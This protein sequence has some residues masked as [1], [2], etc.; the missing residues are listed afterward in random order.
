MKVTVNPC[1][2]RY[3]HSREGLAYVV[4]ASCA[5]GLSSVAK[6]EPTPE[7]YA[8]SFLQAHHYFEPLRAFALQKLEEYHATHSGVSA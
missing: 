4:R 7:L 5:C 6:G 2:V 3:H 1:A 8:V